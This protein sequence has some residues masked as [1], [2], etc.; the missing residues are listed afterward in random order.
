MTVHSPPV[1]LGSAFA[2]LDGR[3]PDIRA[4]K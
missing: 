2:A 3:E 4:I 1:S